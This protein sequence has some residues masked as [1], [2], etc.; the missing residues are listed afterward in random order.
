MIDLA[1][2]TG[3]ARVALG[4]GAAGGV[5]HAAGRRS[6]RCCATAR[7]VADPLW[8]MP[9][10]SGYDD[11]IASKVADI[12]NVS[13]GAFAGAIIGA[14]FL[15]AL[16]DADHRLAARRPVRLESR[17]IGRAVPWAPRR[18]PCARC[19]AMLD[20][21]LRRSSRAAPHGPELRAPRLDPDLPV[22]RTRRRRHRRRHG[23]L[24]VRRPG[25]E[26][27]RRSGACRRQLGAGLVEPREPRVRAARAGP[28][29]GRLPGAVAGCVVPRAW[30]RLRSCRSSGAGLVAVLR[31]VRVGAPARGPASRPC[32]RCSGA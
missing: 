22:P 5:R 23:A 24:A 11:D 29:E 18:R 3:A 8:Q 32:A 17:R 1:T 14:L 10:W 27:R 9:L 12:N 6:M 20:G 13:A 15:R 7:R 30:R 21:A 2:L 26:A 31:A 16:R 28:P 19:I 25:P 4:S